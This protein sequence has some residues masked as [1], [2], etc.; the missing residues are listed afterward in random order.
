M[1]RPAAHGLI[2]ILVQH[3]ML[4]SRR[5]ARG[6]RH[7]KSRPWAGSG[8]MC[9]ALPRCPAGAGS[10]LRLGD[11]SMMRPHTRTSAPSPAH[12]HVGIVTKTKR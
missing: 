7:I 3:R 6:H 12:I 5:D 11:R 2:T 9:N 1:I 8:R 10:D 4:G